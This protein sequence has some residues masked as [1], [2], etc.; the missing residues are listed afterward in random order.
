MSRDNLLTVL[1]A[2]VDKLKDEKMRAVFGDWTKTVQYVIT[3]LGEQW[4]IRITGGEAELVEGKVD[5]PDLEYQMNSETF[6][7]LNSGELS[8]MVAYASGAVKAK[9]SV[10]DMMKWRKLSD[11]R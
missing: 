4:A 1:R 11:I 5:A 2:N 10:R 9:G 7:K 8:G 6:L 3:D